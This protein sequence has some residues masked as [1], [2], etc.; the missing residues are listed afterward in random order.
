MKILIKYLGNKYA[1]EIWN[2]FENFLEKL[3]KVWVK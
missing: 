3:E 2:N 1:E